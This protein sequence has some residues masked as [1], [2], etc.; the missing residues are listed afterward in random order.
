MFASNISG[1]QRLPDGNTLVCVGPEGRLLEVTPGGETVWS[2]TVPG[3][4]PAVFRAT[5]IAGD[6]PALIGRVLAPGGPIAN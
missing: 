6:H 5:R 4:M 2:Y 3:A 1:A